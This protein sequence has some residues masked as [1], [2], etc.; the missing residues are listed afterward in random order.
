MCIQYNKVNIIN[1]RIKSTEDSTKKFKTYFHYG[2]H[3]IKSISIKYCIIVLA[4]K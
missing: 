3:L 4:Y 2:P 1:T